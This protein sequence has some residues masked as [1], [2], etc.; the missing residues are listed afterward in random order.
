MALKMYDS[1]GYYFFT[2][3]MDV[4][5]IEFYVETYSYKKGARL[6]ETTYV[7][8]MDIEENPDLEELFSRKVVR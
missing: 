5:D 4:E 3:P 7:K 6:I 2:V 1:V 8:N